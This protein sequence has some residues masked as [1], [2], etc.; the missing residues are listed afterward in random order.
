MGISLSTVKR[1]WNLA[2]AW[3]YRHLTRSDSPGP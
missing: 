1:E 3:L 2:R